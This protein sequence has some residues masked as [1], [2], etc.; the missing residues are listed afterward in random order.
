M[1]STDVLLA[2]SRALGGD[3]QGARSLVGEIRDG[4]VGRAEGGFAALWRPDD[5]AATP[6]RGARLPAPKPM[7]AIAP[8]AKVT[9]RLP[10]GKQVRVVHV[11]AAARHRDMLDVAQVNDVNTKLAFAAIAHNGRAIDRLASS[12]DVLA[13]R[14][15]KLQSDG[16]LGLLRGMVEGLA[17]LESRLRHVERAQHRGLEA[18]ARSTRKQLARL[19]RDVENQERNAGAQK[20]HGAVATLQSIAMAT[21]G[22]L[23]TRENLL[24]ALNQIGWSF[25]A[26]ILQSA[27][28]GASSGVAATLAWLAP[29][30]NLATSKVVIGKGK[31]GGG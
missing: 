31:G 28:G 9:M 15:T 16:D 17:A 1:V 20:L 2:V 13:Y 11:P 4:I 14:V 18:Q 19:S 21:Q 26:Q 8:A 24:L 22:E 23:L 3:R 7:P 29:L 5:V 10:S 27:G 25:G 12:H 6:I 30:G